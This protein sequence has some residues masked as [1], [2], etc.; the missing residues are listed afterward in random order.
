M[1]CESVC[2]K[3]CVTTFGQCN[4][5]V[6]IHRVT[7][8]NWLQILLHSSPIKIDCYKNR[9][10]TL[11]LNIIVDRKYDLLGTDNVN[12]W[13]S[14]CIANVQRESSASRYADRK[15][16]LALSTFLGHWKICHWPRKAHELTHRNT[17]KSCWVTSGGPYSYVNRNM[18]DTCNFLVV[19]S[20]A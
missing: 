13:I 19:S 10:D 4:S 7:Q 15:W 16:R 20:Y 14:F 2:I 6:R 3:R 9:C 18:L 12:G 11:S 1:G 8:C 17:N 5:T